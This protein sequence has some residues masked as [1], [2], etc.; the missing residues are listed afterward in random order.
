M[1]LFGRR[2][3]ND[4]GG[5]LASAPNVSDTQRDA[6]N[7]LFDGILREH[8]EQAAIELIQEHAALFLIDARKQ[9]MPS[10][11]IDELFS[12]YQYFTFALFT[13]FYREKGLQGED[14]PREAGK[15]ADEMMQ[16]VGAAVKRVIANPD[17]YLEKFRRL[18]SNT[19][20]YTPETTDAIMIENLYTQ[21]GVGV[22]DLVINRHDGKPYWISTLRFPDAGWQTGIFD[23]SLSS[24]LTQ[25]LFRLN[26]MEVAPAALFNHVVAIALVAE[27]RPH[28]WPRGMYWSRPEL[29]IWTDRV[30]VM[31]AKLNEKFVSV[32]QS[33][34]AE[35]KALYSEVRRLYQ[36]EHM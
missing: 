7:Q 6:I 30:V 2:K 10:Q 13:T 14:A 28:D 21:T 4:V 25:P 8:G 35:Y 24:W 17:Y 27:A 9:G 29:A 31:E 32:T 3:S 12:G 15:R 23:R 18:S 33:G 34:D 26:E 36:S 16:G 20:F 11:E 5:A 1:G 22:N 19:S